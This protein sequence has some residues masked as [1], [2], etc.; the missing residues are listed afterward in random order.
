MESPFE[1]PRMATAAARQISPPSAERSPWISSPFQSS[2]LCTVPQSM[3]REALIEARI[4]AF[5]GE[6]NTKRPTTSSHVSQRD[7]FVPLC[8]F[9]Q[10]RTEAEASVLLDLETARR[11]RKARVSGRPRARSRRAGGLR[12]PRIHVVRVRIDRIAVL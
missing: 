3:W 9:Q 5:A 11:T 8:G 10:E 4:C 1:S 2:A 7:I 6:A 12:W